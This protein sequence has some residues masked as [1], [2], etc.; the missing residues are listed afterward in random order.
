MNKKDQSRIDISL[1]KV[2]DIYRWIKE[3]KPSTDY[4]ANEFNIPFNIAFKILSLYKIGR[5]PKYIWKEIKPKTYTMNRGG[6]LVGKSHDEGGISIKTPAGE[7]EMEGGESIINKEATAKHCEILSDLNQSEGNGVAFDCPKTNESSASNYMMYG[8]KTQFS[9]KGY[10]FKKSIKECYD[11]Y[12]NGREIKLKD[13]INHEELFKKYPLIGEVKVKFD[14]IR[15]NTLG[16]Y[17]ETNVNE[18]KYQLSLIIIRL[19]FNYY[20]NNNQE[21]DELTGKFPEFSK[22]AALLH[23]IQHVCQVSDKR[24]FGRSY[25]EY[26]NEYRPYLYLKMGKHKENAE[27]IRQYV[28]KQYKLQPAEQEAMKTV[29]K[30]LKEKGLNYGD[31]QHIKFLYNKGGITNNNNMENNKYQKGGDTKTEKE[32]NEM[33][34]GLLN[35]LKEDGKTKRHVT[36]FGQKVFETIK[37]NKEQKGL[38]SRYHSADQHSLGIMQNWGLDEKEV[39]RIYKDSLREK[40]SGGSMAGG[41]NTSEPSEMLVKLNWEGETESILFKRRKDGFYVGKSWKTNKDYTYSYNTLVEFK[42]QTEGSMAAGGE[43]KTKNDFELGTPAVYHSINYSGEHIQETGEIVTR[44]GQKGISL[45]PDANYSGS[46]ERFRI[47]D[48]WNN[49]ET[50]SEASKRSHKNKKFII[51]NTMEQ[52]GQM[53]YSEGGLDCLCK[54]KLGSKHIEPGASII[55]K[56]TGIVSEVKEVT[57]EGLIVQEKRTFNGSTS[58]PVQVTWDEIQQKF[59]NGDIDISGY[60]HTDNDNKILYLMGENMKHGGKWKYEKGGKMEYQQGGKLNYPTER[61]TIQDESIEERELHLYIDND[62]DLYRQR[63]TPIIKNLMTKIARGEFDINLAPKIFI[64]LI[65][66]GIKKYSK[67]H[68]TITLTK[69]EKDNLSKIYVNDFLDE[70]RYG[71]YENE[72]FLPKKYLEEGGSM[73]TGGGIDMKWEKLKEGQLVRNKKTGEIVKATKEKFGTR[74]FTDTGFFDTIHTKWEVVDGSMAKGGIVCPRGT[75]VQTILFNKKAFS[76]D[77]AKKW[78][79]EH[80]YKFSKVDEKPKVWRFRQEKPSAFRPNSFR[81]IKFSPEVSAI[82]GCKKKKK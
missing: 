80:D 74:S 34:N 54:E 35:K 2:E 49:V 27:A 71:N 37:P 77:E 45:Y 75:S 10:V 65:E 76:K 42:N 22:E 23:E 52:G 4:L 82:I 21:R 16:A 19:N 5:N 30:W 11:L 60:E 73:A 32:I 55:G 14:N 6:I 24:D 43:I 12:K 40:Y 46:G 44:D 64:Y 59:E 26:Y 38:Y 50:F 61:L 79:N 67:E 31:R 81:T 47:P 70:A 66:D 53:E 8:G 58:S 33:A 1:E 48:N 41:G 17:S 39:L 69:T 7:V 9:D 68:G 72:T 36:Y 57:P 78:L 20:E 56:Q 18:E 63:F 51:T 3:R 13:L 29:Y 62:G 28:I 15:D 25:D